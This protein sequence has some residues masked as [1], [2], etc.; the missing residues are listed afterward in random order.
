MAFISVVAPV[1]HNAESLPLLIKSLTK[2]AGKLNSD[3]FEYIFVDDG[4]QDNSF[5]VLK[6]LA[7]TDVGIKVVKLSRNFGSNA[8]ILAG[9]THATGDSIVTL[10]ADLQDPP[11]IIPA[12]VAA[13][14]EGFPIVLAARR[15]RDD[16]F[17]SRIFSTLFNR[18][19]RR[20]IFP[21]FPANGFDFML[22]DRKV[23]DILVNLK[24]KNSYIFGQVMWVGFDRQVIY[25]DRAKRHH[26]QSR[27]TFA[28]KIKYMI[29][30]F[31]AFSYLPLRITSSLGFI[32]STLGFLYSVLIIALRLFQNI[33]VIG[34]ASLTVVVLITSGVQLIMVGILGE[35]LW[36]TLDEARHRPAYIIENTINIKPVSD[37]QNI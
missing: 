21:E 35:Y 19:F 24:E 37:K 15:Q 11:D 6:N 12:L 20:F 33:Q 2:V 27:W 3:E 1:F 9:L 28:K 34:W 16:P 17:V 14:K 36:R 4:S 26:G 10:A 13:W 29:D 18:L 7:A 32:L 25:Y 5:Q 8:A 31:A 30:A 22:I 23:K